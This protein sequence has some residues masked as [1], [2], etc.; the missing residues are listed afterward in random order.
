MGSWRVI[1]DMGVFVSFLTYEHVLRL[2]A[3]MAAH[4]C[5]CI[6]KSLNGVLSGDES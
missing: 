6:K 3:V 2:T 5:E 4:I 1:K